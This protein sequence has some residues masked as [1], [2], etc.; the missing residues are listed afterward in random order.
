MTDM[1]GRHIMVVSPPAFHGSGVDFLFGSAVKELTRKDDRRKETKKKQ[2]NIS[3]I[4]L[5]DGN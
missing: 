5:T 2:R 4:L 1:E 3:K